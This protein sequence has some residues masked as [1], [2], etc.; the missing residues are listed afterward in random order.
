[1]RSSLLP[2]PWLLAAALAA[3][4]GA[5]AA[6]TA[7]STSQ[8]PACTAT[9]STGTGAFFDLRPDTAS[10]QESGKTPKSAVTKDYHARGWDYGKNFTLNICGPVVEPVEDVVGLKKGLWADV[11]AY[12]TSHDDVYSLG[13]ASMDLRSRGRKLVLQYTG[14]SP[15]GESKSSNRRSDQAQARQD[16]ADH[17]KRAPSPREDKKAAAAS[18]ADAAKARRKSATISFLCDRDPGSSTAISFVGTDPDE[19]A[20]FFEARSAHA[21]GHAEPHKPGSVGPGS[22]F[23]LIL[24]I[25]VLVYVLGG[26][27]Y[28]RTVAHARGWRQLPNYS[29][30]AGIWSFFFVR[31]SRPKA[32]LSYP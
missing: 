9:A 23:G 13:F 29:L 12:Y 22:V 19:C 32:G 27:F 30:W 1:M 7:S 28:N 20:Y 25:A 8:A 2:T 26:V 31:P 15:C 18:T 5:G 4:A 24:A 21:C 17:A 11:G 10:L 14:G 3:G 16:A 6:E